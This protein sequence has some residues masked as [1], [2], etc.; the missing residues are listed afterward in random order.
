M[1]LNSPYS[2]ISI[3]SNI[4]FN[5]TEVE[6]SLYTSLMKQNFFDFFENVESF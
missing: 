5:S 1:K 3:K 6:A 4:H 2:I